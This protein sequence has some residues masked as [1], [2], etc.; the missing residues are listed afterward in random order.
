M[1]IDSRTVV[2]TVLFVAVAAVVYAVMTT[3]EHRTV[4][5]KVGDAVEE[6]HDRTPAQRLRDKMDDV[7]ND[8]PAR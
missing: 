5:Q 1:N 8:R 7:T 4:G 2:L 6:L 3:P